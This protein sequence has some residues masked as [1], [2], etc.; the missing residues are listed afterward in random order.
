MM[1]N[2]YSGKI[3]LANANDA[4][5]SKLMKVLFIALITLVSAFSLWA[6]GQIVEGSCVLTA[7]SNVTI[8]DSLLDSSDVVIAASTIN[9][10]DVNFGSACSITTVTV[11]AVDFSNSGYSFGVEMVAPSDPTPDIPQF[12]F[13]SP[14]P[15]FQIQLNA[16]VI[17]A[18]PEPSTLALG[19]LALG[20]MVMPRLN[21]FQ[22]FL[23]TTR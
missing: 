2:N 21:K 13:I 3:E 8:T 20:L 12:P 23:N 17:Q 16:G 6:Q 22:R 7:A 5:H 14:P 19:G 9:L 18:V 4:T 1:P 10:V 11:G 15:D